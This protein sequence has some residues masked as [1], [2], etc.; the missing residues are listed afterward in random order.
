MNMRAAD[1]GAWLTVAGAKTPFRKETLTTST[2]KPSV[3]TLLLV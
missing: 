1:L 3:D 2:P